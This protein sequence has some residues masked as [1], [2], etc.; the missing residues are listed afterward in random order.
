MARLVLA[1]TSPRR[2]RL[3]K[4]AGFEFDIRRPSAEE[5]LTGD[6]YSIAVE[7]ARA[8]ARSVERSHDETIIGADTIVLCDGRVLGKPKDREEAGGM[9]IV[10]LDHPQEVITG[11]CIISGGS[12]REV[13]GYEISRLVMRGDPLSIERYLDTDQ[14]QGKAGGYGI[15]D[16]GGMVVDLVRGNF[17][18][19]AGLP[20]TLLRRLLSL[21][22]YEYPEKTPSQGYSGRRGSSN[23]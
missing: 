11:V 9:L 18:N 4:E 12:G 15:Q 5:S 8:K 19:V 23:T 7:N 1:S 6:P 2:S 13:H 10:Q 20:L 17:D 16:E 14:W 21:L 22:D 3:L